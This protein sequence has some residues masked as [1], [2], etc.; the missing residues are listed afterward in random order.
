M[1]RNAI[2]SA[3]EEE[4]AGDLDALDTST[5]ATSTD[6]AEPLPKNPKKGTRMDVLSDVLG[7]ETAAVGVYVDSSLLPCMVSSQEPLLS[8][9]STG[10]L[11]L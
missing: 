9:F 2:V 11:V 5:T 6:C 1:E 3:V 7:A 10:Q 4:L 8:L